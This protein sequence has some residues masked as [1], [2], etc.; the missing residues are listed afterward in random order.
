MKSLIHG[1]AALV[2]L[3]ASAGMFAGVIV[4]LGPFVDWMPPFS[5]I[6]PAVGFPADL[7]DLSAYTA[8]NILAG[9]FMT[10][11]SGFFSF[12][13]VFILTGPDIPRDIAE[14]EAYKDA[15]AISE[16][17]KREI[18]KPADFKAKVLLWI[19]VILAAL[20][21]V[22]VFGFFLLSSA[23]VVAEWFFGVTNSFS[24]FVAKHS[25]GLYEHSRA[26]AEL[27]FMML[28]VVF[29]VIFWFYHLAFGIL[30]STSD[31]YANIELYDAAGER[32]IIKIPGARWRAAFR[33]C[34]NLWPILAALLCALIHV[35]FV[36][37]NHV[38]G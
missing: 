4:A 13:A 3:A 34:L 35:A 22:G 31:A 7:S 15:V 21:S 9:G 10:S 17:Y 16:T 38:T 1:I 14:S 29:P 20:F 19:Q 8:A 6:A 18:D 2:Y 30:A 36:S 12:R 5:R 11:Y 26:G 25:P 28:F 33:I 27:L 23:L 37:P 24:E 32:Y